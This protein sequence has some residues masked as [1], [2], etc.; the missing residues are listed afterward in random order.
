VLVAEDN[1]VNQLLLVRLLEKRGHGVQV[2]LDGL[3]ALQ[4]L[5][6]EI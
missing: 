6:K 5:E 3:A 4:A 2:V 1:P